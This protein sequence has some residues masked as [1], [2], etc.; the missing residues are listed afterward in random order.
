LASRGEVLGSR[1]KL[2]GKNLQKQKRC[3]LLEC[4]CEDVRSSLAGGKQ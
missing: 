1:K 2:P 4:S 3:G